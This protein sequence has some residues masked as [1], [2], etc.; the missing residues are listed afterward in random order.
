MLWQS[1]GAEEVWVLAH[2]QRE[3]LPQV[4]RI[5]GEGAG[6]KSNNVPEQ[7]SVRFVRV[8]MKYVWFQLPVLQSIAKQNSGM[9]EV[10]SSLTLIRNVQILLPGHERVVV[11]H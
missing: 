4:G 5:P 2:V 9:N 3:G 1:C 10:D 6:H 7:F 11:E 8:E